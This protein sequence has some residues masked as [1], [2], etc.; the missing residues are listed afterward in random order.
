MSRD[1]PSSCGSML[2][3]DRYRLDETT[4]RVVVDSSPGRRLLPVGLAG[5][6]HALLFSALFLI[7][8][9]RGDLHLPQ[10][11]ETQDVAFMVETIVEPTPPPPAPSA[12]TPP[13]PPEVV[14]IPEPA[15]PPPPPEEEAEVIEQ[16]K[17]EKPPE[18]ERI[19]KEQTPPPPRPRVQVSQVQIKPERPRPVL[20]KP[21]PSKPVKTA[22]MAATAPQASKPQKTVVK[23][24]FIKPVYPAYLNNPAPRYPRNA[25]RRRLE[26]VVELKVTVDIQGQVTALSLF[27]SCGHKSLDQAALNTVRHWRFLPAKHNGKKIVSDVIVPI[28]F[29]LN[30]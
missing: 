16:A 12:P 20:S 29:R 23:T 10:E 5:G 7:G 26:G 22:A 14:E 28:R 21:Q 2:T 24:G 11:E 27:K 15:P 13:Q 6:L 4:G 8:N 3:S 30:G 19:E 25:K 9:A 1:A 17:E 18:P